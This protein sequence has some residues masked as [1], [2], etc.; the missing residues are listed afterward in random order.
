M[1]FSKMK[2]AIFKNEWTLVEKKYIITDTNDEMLVL[3]WA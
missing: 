2:N 3:T 1:L